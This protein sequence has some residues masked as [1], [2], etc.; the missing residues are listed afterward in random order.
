MGVIAAQHVAD[1]GGRLLERLVR[2]ET[3]LVHGVQYAPVH[4]LETV[5]HVGKRTRDDDAH[6]VVNK[7]G[8]HLADDL[9]RDNLLLGEHYIFWLVIFG[10]LV[11]TLFLIRRGGLPRPPGVRCSASPDTW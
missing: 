11:T 10:H 1:A 6:G 4:G 5:A 7:A 3:V 2:R 8:L 9:R